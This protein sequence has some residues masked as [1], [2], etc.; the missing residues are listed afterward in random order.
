MNNLL[1]IKSIALLLITL[2][3]SAEVYACHAVT[4]L[5]FQLT[6]VTGGINVN[7]SS[8]QVTCGCT[9]IYWLDIEVRCMGEP[10]DGAPFSPGFYGPL[11]SYPY[12]QSAQMNK[13]GCQ[14]IPYPTTFIPYTSMCPGVTYQVRV[15]ENHNGQASTW[16]TALQF[17]VPGNVDPLVVQA[18]ATDITICAGQC[19]TLSADVI[20]GCDFAPLYSWSNGANTQT[21][22]VCPTTTT[23]YT[24]NVTEQCSGFSDQAS[25]TINVLPPPVAG[26]ASISNTTICQGDPLS[27]SLAGYAGNVQ[28]QSAPG[29]GGPWSNVGGATN[30]VF[31]PGALPVGTHCFRAEVVGCGAPLIRIR[32]VL[33]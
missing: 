25:I 31:N 16:T 13:P 15:R 2:W 10:F 1:R 7:A 12:F 28:W 27:A 14:L 21:T 29:A 4:P 5:N 3:F 11:N 17:T 32:C 8:S 30:D 20:G 23:T 22:T 9:N 19:T 6:P 26:T 18:N 24:V 33:R